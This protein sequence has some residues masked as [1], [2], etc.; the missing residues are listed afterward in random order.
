MGGAINT[1]RETGVSSLSAFPNRVWERG[2]KEAPG[3][4]RP[5]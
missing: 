1:A 5:G 4:M 2:N 3:N